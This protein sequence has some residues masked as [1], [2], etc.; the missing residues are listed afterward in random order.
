MK[1]INHPIILLKCVYPSLPP[2]VPSGGDLGTPKLTSAVESAYDSTPIP[3]ATSSD[4]GFSQEEDVMDVS[5]S[6]SI[7]EVPDIALPSPDEQDKGEERET[8]PEDGEGDKV[9]SRSAG[10]N[11][12]DFLLAFFGKK[13]VNEDHTKVLVKASAL[14][15]FIP[16]KNSPRK[17]ETR[18]VGP[19]SST[20]LQVLHASLN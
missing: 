5:T 2:T 18:K 8:C 9:E 13:N 7:D 1:S 16:G 6:S 4:E 12:K 14:T 17:I 10:K 20:S 11:R 3:P 19:T 15:S